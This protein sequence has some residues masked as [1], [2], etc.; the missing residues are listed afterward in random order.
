MK[1]KFF[2]AAIICATTSMSVLGQNS[3][4]Y[5]ANR[6]SGSSYRNQNVETIPTSYNDENEMTITIKGIYNEKATYQ[7]AVFSILQIGKTAEET[8][9]LM[10]E[11]INNTI[12][13]LKNLGNEI[14]VVIDFISFIPSYDYEVQ[15]KI[16]NP[17][18]Y[19][20]K[21]SGFELK[22]NLIVKYKNT[23]DLNKI[24]SIC[25]QEEIYDLAKVD[26]ITTNMDEI[27]NTLHDK[28]LLEYKRLLA[29]YSFIMNVD[30]S[31]KKKKIIDASNTIY[32]MESY[33]SYT[34]YSQAAINFS[35]SSLVNNIKKNNTQFYDGA[36]LKTHSFVINPEITEPA[37][38]LFY[39]LTIKI[40]LNEDHLPKNTIQVNNKYYIIT[41]TG[42][43]KALVL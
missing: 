24:I 23:N 32:P 35:P 20:E 26:Y 43:I 10:D 14:D 7:R 18:T 29:E 42:T 21:P 4:N 36:M 16:F 25:S 11:R 30:L 28:V 8:N 1:T 37:I 3:G 2:L 31:K 6:S 40:K 41:P 39:D 38:Q 34:A 13:R 27:R 9:K 5:N 19:N 17:R 33:K 15:K 12:T 22:K